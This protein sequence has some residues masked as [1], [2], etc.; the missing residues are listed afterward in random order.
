MN[1]AKK[2]K[3]YSTTIEDNYILQTNQDNEKIK[4]LDYQI[5]VI[6]QLLL[7]EISLHILNV[8][9]SNFNSCKL[10]LVKVRLV[11]SPTECF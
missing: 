5:T 11:G 4:W 6:V 9:Y 8:N 10:Q 1:F 7:T 3:T 2:N